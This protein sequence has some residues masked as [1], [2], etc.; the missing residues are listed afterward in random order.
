MA[1]YTAYRIPLL[2]ENYPSKYDALITELQNRATEMENGRQGQA[3][4]AANFSRYILASAGLTQNLA[5]NGFRVTG[6]PVP[7]AADEPATKSFAEGLAFSSALP[8]ISLNVQWLGVTNDGSAGRW[9]HSA[10][11]ATAVLGA[12]FNF[13][14]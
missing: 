14:G 9:G 2:D 6:L 10:A 3:S 8:S 13:Y 11:E 5:A 12:L 1:D 4:L 7:V